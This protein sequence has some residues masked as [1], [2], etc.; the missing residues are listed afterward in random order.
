MS[1]YQLFRVVVAAVVHNKNGEFLMAQRHLKDDNQ[2]GI[3]AIPAGHIEVEASNTNIL[4]DN[5]RREV[6]EEVGIEIN[7]ERYLESHSWVAEDYKKLTIVFLCTIKSG[8]PKA[9]SET[10]EVSWLSLA[11]IRKLNCAPS[12]LRVIEKAADLL[13]QTV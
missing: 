5:L 3:W 7:I 2:P 8:E 12:V 10:E 1:E 13:R 6:K 11:E 9:L 4:E